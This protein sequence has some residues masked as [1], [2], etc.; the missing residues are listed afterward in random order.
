MTG[1]GILSRERLTAIRD[2][3]ANCAVVSIMLL[4]IPVTIL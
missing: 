1:S 4:A 3:A 2:A